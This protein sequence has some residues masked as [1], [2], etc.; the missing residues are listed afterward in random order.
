MV[1]PFK[2][3]AA[4]VFEAFWQRPAAPTA[5]AMGVSKRNC[6]GFLRSF[7]LLAPRQKRDG[8]LVKIAMQTPCQFENQA[9]GERLKQNRHLFDIW[10]DNRL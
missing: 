8:L 4:K 7:V 10:I 9:H 5:I 3:I 6:P 1:R 2:W